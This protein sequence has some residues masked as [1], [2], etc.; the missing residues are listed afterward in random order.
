MADLITFSA[1]LHMGPLRMS[2]AVLLLLVA[3]PVRVVALK[4]FTN[5]LRESQAQNPS[6]SQMNNLPG[7]NFTNFA[8]MGRV[9]A[10]PAVTLYS[11]P[12]PFNQQTAASTSSP[13]KPPISSENSP[14]KQNKAPLPPSSAPSS[15]T[16]ST[17]AGGSSST[18]NTPSL[19]NASLKRKQGDN[20]TAVTEQQPPT[21][22][23]SRRQR[24][25]R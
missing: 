20:A 14:L 4:E 7:T 10:S 21:K 15:T 6:N 19:S 17:P 24:T 16:A 18:H 8:N 11:I 23:M 5:R 22:R 2:C 3:D 9:S 13:P 12:P 25:N 1:E